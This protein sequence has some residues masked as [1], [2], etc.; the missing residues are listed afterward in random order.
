MYSL[1]LLFEKRLGM[2]LYVPCGMDWWKEKMWT[3]MASTSPETAMQYLNWNVKQDISEGRNPYTLK[4]M[5]LDEAKHAN[6]D[7]IMS[8]IP[9]HD[10]PFAKL[11]QW[12]KDAILIS[13]WGNPHQ[14]CDFKLYKNVLNSTLGEVPPG[15][16]EVHYHQ[17]FNTEEFCYTEPT[18]DKTVSSFVIFYTNDP[19]ASKFREYRKSM[20]DYDFKMYGHGDDGVYKEHDKAQG[21]KDTSFLWHIKTQGDGYGH[22]IH[23]AYSVGRSAITMGS[24]FKGMP[25][26]KL[27][28]PETAIDLEKVTKQQAMDKMREWSADIKN[29]SKRV[30]AQFDREINFD[31]D[32]V[33]I[34]KWLKRCV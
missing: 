2:E 25:P 11:K 24:Y 5:T 33:E 19:T 23:T 32:E 22:S 31:K 17:E 6:L 30:R 28:T 12:N 18:N 15:I 20:P 27:F 29:V 3:N 9:R 14:T 13:Q 8:S 26:S 34:R 10:E 21:M 16:N 4:G 7:Y 1:H